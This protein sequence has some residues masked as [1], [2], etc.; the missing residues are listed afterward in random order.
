MGPL[1]GGAFTTDVTWRWCFFINLPI[2]LAA[3]VVI[4]FLLDIPNTTTTS[5]TIAQKIRKVNP[6]GISALVP[7]VVSLCLA[8]QWGGTV[9]AWN[10]GRVVATLTIGL[11]LLV[12]FVAMQFWSGDEAV[13]PPRIFSQRSIA[14]AFWV[15]CC[16]GAHQLLLLYYLPIWFQAVQGTSAVESGIRLLPMMIPVVIASVVSGKLISSTGYYAPFMIAGVCLTAV[17]AGLITTFNIYTSAGMWIGYQVIYGFGFGLCGQTPNMAAQTVLS[18]KE[19]AIGASFMLFGQQLFGAIFTSVGQNVLNN[20]LAERLSAFINFDPA[21][22]Q[23]TGATEI[24]SKIPAQFHTQALMAYNGSLRVCFQV[25]LIMACL[26]II[27]CLT[28]EW[29]SVKQ[30]KP[31]NTTDVEKAAGDRNE[32]IGVSERASIQ[33]IDTK[34]ADKEKPTAGKDHDDSN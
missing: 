24:L 14:S 4:V 3:L 2:G 29:L 15:S 34:E 9:Y 20:Q 30:G 26:A 1:V 27:G 17:G 33:E 7:G 18:K 31:S 21:S 11:A 5:L 6:L 25:G 13:L 22:I 12:A 16:L 19:V 28:I 8:L 23:S 32:S 10:D